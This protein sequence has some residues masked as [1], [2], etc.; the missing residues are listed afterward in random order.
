LIKSLSVT[1]QGISAQ[2][3]AIQLL[4]YQVEANIIG[5]EGIPALKDTVASIQ[6]SKEQFC[7]YYEEGVLVGVISYSIKDNTL[8]IHRLIVHPQHFRKGIGRAL[9]EYVLYLGR[10][11][12][13]RY[14]VWTA[15]SN[16]PA[17]DLYR[18][19]GFQEEEQVE[20]HPTIYITKFEQIIE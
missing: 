3:L 5:F 4:S 8:E 1:S 15:S 2:V 12:I 14:I 10:D 20:V 7:G 6:K 16:Y 13:S 11:N 18:S 17:V 19:L 9:V